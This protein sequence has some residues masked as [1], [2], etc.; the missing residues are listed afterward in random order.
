MFRKG[1]GVARRPQA[2]PAA[3]GGR[4]LPDGISAIPTLLLI[5][6][7]QVVKKFVGLRTKR[8]LA[9]EIDAVLG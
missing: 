1:W 9:Q 8:D 7:G 6:D 3:S 2:G 4:V 5:K